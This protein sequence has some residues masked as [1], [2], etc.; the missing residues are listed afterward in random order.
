MRESVVRTAL[1]PFLDTMPPAPGPSNRSVLVV[2]ATGLVGAE[3]VKQ[4][5]ADPTVGRVVVV[6]RRIPDGLPARVE[7]H[8]LDFEQ[9][10]DHESLFAV[11]QIICALG[12]TIRQAGSQAAFRKVDFEYP[13]TVARLGHKMGARHFLLVSALG[14]NSGSGIFYNRVKGELED[15]LR[16]LGYRSVSI[17]RP[18]LLLGARKQFRLFERLGMVIGEIV[19][20]RYRPVRAEAVAR[21]LVTAARIDAPGLH[22]IESE[23]IREGVD[24]SR[25]GEVPG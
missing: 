15:Q 7:S 22:I 11:D 18:S 23:E 3:V 25:A 6:A 17:A 13:L 4:L 20:G 19:P 21:S 8:T 24:P 2:G 12:T 9:L 16:S 5:A 1:S 10:R 14:A